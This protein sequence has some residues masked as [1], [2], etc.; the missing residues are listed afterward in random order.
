MKLR[1]LELR[2]A[3]L[4]LE[5]MHDERATHDLQADFS[6]K[7]IQ[8]AENFIRASW[9]DN[10]NINLAIV[11]DL[12]E[13]MGTVSLK[14]VQ[15][16]SA[17]FAIIVR[18]SVMGRGYSK[19]GM[20]KILKMGFEDMD[21]QSIYWCVDPANKRAVRFY[22]KNGYKKTSPDRIVNGGIRLRY[23]KEQIERY[24]WYLVQAR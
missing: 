2:D 21:L 16:G 23:S 24:Y 22:D 15:N 1:R 3:P 7:T 10:E 13:Y 11:C 20:E 4:M 9:N 5:W 18:T 6:K 17:E 14:H 19:Y 8:D 12:D